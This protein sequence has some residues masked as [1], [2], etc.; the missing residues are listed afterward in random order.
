MI[1]VHN[2]ISLRGH[3]RPVD[4]INMDRVAAFVA[5]GPRGGVLLYV[6]WTPESKTPWIHLD[7]ED[8]QA[9]IHWLAERGLVALGEDDERGA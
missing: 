9:V 3:T 2:W 5:N 1:G 7:G 6:G 4:G 8:A